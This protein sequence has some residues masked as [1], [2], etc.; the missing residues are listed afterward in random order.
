MGNKMSEEKKHYKKITQGL[1]SSIQDTDRLGFAGAM[2]IGPWI[3]PLAP[4]IIFGWALY[5][6]APKTM[7]NELRII[8]GS[9]AALGLVVAGA[10]SSH[11]AI[12]LQTAE[13]KGKILAFAW[14]LVFGYIALEITGLWK[15]NIEKEIKIVGTVISLLTLVVYLSRSA[16][17][18]LTEIKQDKAQ[19]Q[20]L[21]R[22]DKAQAQ[23]LTREDDLQAQRLKYEAK[24]QEQVHQ[25]EMEKLRLQMEQDANLAKI[26][27][28]KEKAIAKLSV[29]PPVSQSVSPDTPDLTPDEQKDLLLHYMEEKPDTTLTQLAQDVGTSRSTLY[30][31]LDELKAAGKIKVNGAGYTINR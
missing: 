26:E 11:N 18:R 12:S 24:L 21:E 9:A 25:H 15:M 1:I 10:V 23:Q 5:E 30:R 28:N 17:S 19:A 29:S 14:L 6:S 31:R 20:Q 4:A 2:G 27:A 13:I 22:K 7:S 8:A 16:A 3:V